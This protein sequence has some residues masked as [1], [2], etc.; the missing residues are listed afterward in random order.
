MVLKR[1]RFLPSHLVTDFPI[2][3]HRPFDGSQVCPQ[4]R[5]TSAST[6]SVH[7]R[8][9]LLTKHRVFS[10]PGFLIAQEVGDS[11]YG[12]QVVL[13]HDAWTELK[14]NMDRVRL[15]LTV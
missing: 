1:I 3:P 13:T 7:R 14:D 9:H 4:P 10:G 6:P 11:A 2:S 15:G 8:L 12:G 5:L